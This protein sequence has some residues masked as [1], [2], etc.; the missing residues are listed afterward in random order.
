MLQNLWYR[1]V[2]V[3]KRHFH[4]SFKLATYFNVQD[5]E[6][7]EKRVIQSKE[8]VIVDFFAK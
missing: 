2:C 3:T 5:E 6:D 7:F 1:S 4:Q 8:P